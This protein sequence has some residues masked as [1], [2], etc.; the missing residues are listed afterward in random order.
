MINIDV[1]DYSECHCTEVM[2]LFWCLVCMMAIY[3]LI[4]AYNFNYAC[5]ISHASNQTINWKQKEK[6]TK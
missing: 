3:N 4:S 6:K 2:R 1:L 5:V